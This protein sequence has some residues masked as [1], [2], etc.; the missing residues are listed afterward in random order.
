MGDPAGV[1]P[2]VLIKSYKRAKS[3]LNLIAISDFSKFKY[4]AEKYDVK[5]RKINDVDHAKNF[6]DYLN[7]LHI[8]Y[9]D[10]FSPGNFNSK[11]SS[12][13]IESIR[14]A[15]ELCLKNKVSAMVTGPINKSIL[16]S[17]QAFNFS[18]HTDYIE[19]LCGYEKD[20]ATMMMLNRHLKIIPL[21]IHEPLKQVSLKI[22]ET[23]IE[24]KL[25]VI[26]SELRKS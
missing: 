25:S 12:A 6:K 21:T 4:L 7:I 3:R 24:K 11:N 17:H 8:D 23:I 26:I 14:L 10:A 16:R 5:L 9:S 2:E 19:F 1:G 18:G 15:T 13:V 20:V 22:K